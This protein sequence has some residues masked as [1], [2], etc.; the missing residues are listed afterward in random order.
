MAITVETD[1]KTA[2]VNVTDQIAAA[3]PD[4]LPVATCTVFVPHT[5]AGITVNEDEPGLI[6]D[7]LEALSTLAPADKAY[8]HDRIDDNAAAHLRSTLLGS[9]ETVPVRDGTLAL[10]AWQSLLVV[11]SDGPRSRRL[12]VT[13]TPANPEPGTYR[14]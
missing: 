7:L 2:I 3:V 14:W 6:D 8:A 12:T 4:D 5:T 10:G 9:H 1:A 13:L 11:E